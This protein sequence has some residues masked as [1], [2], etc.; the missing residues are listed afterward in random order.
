MFP[1]WLKMVSIFFIWLF[2]IHISS[3]VKCLCNYPDQFKIII[4]FAFSNIQFWEFLK[5]HSL[6]FLQVCG[7]SSISLLVYLYI[8]I[9][10]MI[11]VALSKILKSGSISPSTLLFCKVVLAILNPLYFHTSFRTLSISTQ[12]LLFFYWNTVECID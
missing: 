11:I 4:L 1:C 12:N 2:A 3:L 8:S 5:I 9:T 10:T 6:Y 7:F